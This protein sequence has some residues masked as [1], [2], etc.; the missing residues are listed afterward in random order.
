M[1]FYILFIFY[2]YLLSENY[3]KVLKKL[4]LLYFHI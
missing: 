1:Y 4:E 2:S 3:L